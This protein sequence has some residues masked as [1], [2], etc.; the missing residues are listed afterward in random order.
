MVSREQTRQN[1]DRLSRWYDRFAGSEVKFTETGLQLLDVRAG[2]RTLEIGFGTGHALVRLALR[3]G[4]SGLAAG[5][6]LSPGMI[7]VARKRVPAEGLEG[8]AH[9]IQ[10]DATLL[11]FLPRSFDAVFLSFTLE[12]FSEAEIP[13]LLRECCRVLKPEGRLGAVSLAQQDT[14]ACRLYQWGHERWPAL[15]DCRPIEL[16]K[17]LE[18]GGF[19][20]Q[21]AQVQT[22]WG[23]PVGIALARPNE[24]RK[25]FNANFAK[26]AN[27]AKNN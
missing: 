22:M 23:L 19:S 26:W 20:I 12:L 27:I 9:M 6:E 3:T 16:E 1:Y 24:L 18:A 7:A 25:E 21:V 4:D 11:P 14:L 13:V 15:L 2:E 5:V 8:C 10:G 17:C